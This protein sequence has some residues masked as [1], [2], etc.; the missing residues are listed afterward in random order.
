MVNEKNSDRHEKLLW[1]Q[2][3]YDAI[4]LELYDYRNDLEYTYEHQLTSEPMRIDVLVVKKRKDV[5]ID[6]NIARIFRGH[7]IIEYKSPDDYFS[8]RDFQQVLAYAYHYAA[9]TPGVDDADLSLTFVGNRYPRAL[10]HYL[11]EE[12]KYTVEQSSP[13]VYQIHGDYL[14]IQILESKLLPK[15]DNLWLKSLRRGLEPESKVAILEEIEKNRHKMRID[16][17]VDVLIEAN[18]DIYEEINA[19]AL[20]IQWIEETLDNLGLPNWARQSRE[21]GRAEEKE[22]IAQNLLTE[23][24]SVEQVARL[25]ELSAAQVRVLKKDT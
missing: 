3:F 8:I 15:S 25:T 1:H 6:K 20:R 7:N 13:G 5:T 4:Q 19:M 11:T 9:N 16:S 23:G 17:Y 18:P 2:A 21:E 12:R 14:P 22:K 24:M 10:L